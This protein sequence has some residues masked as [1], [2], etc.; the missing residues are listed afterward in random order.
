MFSGDMLLNPQIFGRQTHPKRN[1]SKRGH[2][3]HSKKGSSN[4][5]MGI[6]S[7]SNKHLY[8]K[9]KYAKGML[10]NG[11][12]LKTPAPFIPNKRRNATSA[13]H[14]MDINNAIITGN[15]GGQNDHK[16]E[17]INA[18]LT[19]N[20]NQSI[21]DKMDH[22][23]MNKS[24]KYSPDKSQMD[25]NALKQKHNNPSSQRYKLKM[26]FEDNKDLFSN[27]EEG[28][29]ARMPLFGMET[30]KELQALV[31]NDE[32]Y[33]NIVDGQ[34][35]FKQMIVAVLW[36]LLVIAIENVIS[37]WPFSIILATILILILFIQTR[38]S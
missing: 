3:I 23:Q 10:H 19:D 20:N 24:N 34:I 38:H 17:Q 8:S 29:M 13:S 1:K 37:Y 33:S 6:S 22:D 27:K 26:N 30:K 5:K 11:R 16:T 35:P 18:L 7:P 14:S 36:F 31:L 21:S 28:M 2:G 9:Q 15:D 4:S 25:D 12:L 32:Y